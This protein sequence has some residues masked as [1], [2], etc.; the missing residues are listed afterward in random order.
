MCFCTV[1][2]KTRKL[3]PITGRAGSFLELKKIQFQSKSNLIHFCSSF[4]FCLQGQSELCGSYHLLQSCF[5]FFV[6]LHGQLE[7]LVA[8]IFFSLAFVSSSSFYMAKL[9]RLVAASFSSLALLSSSVSTANLRYV[10]VTTSPV[11]V[12]SPTTLHFNLLRV[13]RHCFSWSSVSDD[14]FFSS[15]NLVILVDLSF[16]LL[17]SAFFSS[18]LQSLK[19]CLL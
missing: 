4:F 5:S 12:F 17:S 14:H 1:W 2:T 18:V 16:S 19:L 7:H 15:C 11:F 8:T 10:L 3:V 13:A 6:R 9:N